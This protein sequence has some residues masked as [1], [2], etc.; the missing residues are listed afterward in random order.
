MIDPAV[1]AKEIARLSGLDGF[2]RG[3]DQAGALVELRDALQKAETRDQAHQVVTD[4]LDSQTRCPKPADI[5]LRL[6]EAKGRGEQ[7][8][9]CGRCDGNGS[10]VQYI[11]ATYADN[12]FK[13]KHREVLRD[14]EHY[15][16]VSEWLAERKE[17]NRITLSGAVP[18]PA[19]GANRAMEAA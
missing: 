12:S 15:I 17:T 13:I 19:C 10:I 8:A 6:M 5:R 14:F 9:K 7:R 18:C 3:K 4:W 2:P 16:Q 11:L 1:V